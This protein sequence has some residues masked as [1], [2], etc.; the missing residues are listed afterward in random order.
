MLY[1]RKEMIR[2][3]YE[4]IYNSN[5]LKIIFD[6]KSELSSCKKKWLYTKKKQIKKLQT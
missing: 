3:M 4:S 5:L 1:D 6:L 2:I